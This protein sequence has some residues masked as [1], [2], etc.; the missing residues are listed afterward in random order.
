MASSKGKLKVGGGI[1]QERGAIPGFHQGGIPGLLQK[2]RAEV[3]QRP[4]APTQAERE[5]PC[6]FPGLGSLEF[7]HRLI[8][9]TGLSQGQPQQLPRRCQPLRH[10]LPEH[11]FRRNPAFGAQKAPSQKQPALRSRVGRHMALRQL[12]GRFGLSLRKQAIHLLFDAERRRPPVVRVQA[13]LAIRTRCRPG[14]LQR[15]R[16]A[17]GEICSRP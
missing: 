2:G 5:Y 14:D 1:R 10:Q 8:P 11:P 17:G 9:T 4:A 13:R 7:H 16:P 15:R 3:C 6:L 12:H